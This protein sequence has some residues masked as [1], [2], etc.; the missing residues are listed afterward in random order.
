MRK[1]DVYVRAAEMILAGET[2]WCCSAIS[3]SGLSCKA[4]SALFD[5]APEIK[6][7]L[8][9]PSLGQGWRWSVGEKDDALARK[10]RANALC[11]MAA[12]VEAGDA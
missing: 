6:N 10:Q 1:A 12:M 3:R 9:K 4:F 2:L 8:D 11:F 7:A 5:P